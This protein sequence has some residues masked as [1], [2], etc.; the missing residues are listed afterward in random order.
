MEYGEHACP[1]RLASV[2]GYGR[3]DRSGCLSAVCPSLKL[4]Q[5]ELQLLVVRRARHY[6]PGGGP[7]PFGVS[8]AQISLSRQAEHDLSGSTI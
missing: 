6:G 7:R 3:R 2:G 5:T 8:R 1:E 4:C